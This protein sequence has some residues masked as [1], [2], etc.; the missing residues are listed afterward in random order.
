MAPVKTENVAPLSTYQ[1]TYLT[2]IDLSGLNPRTH[3]KAEDDAELVASIKAEGVLEP[4]LLRPHPNRTGRFQVVAGERRYHASIEAGLINVPAMVRDISDEK[5][6]ELA[7]TEN[8]QRRSM[9]PLDEANGFIKRLDMGQTSPEQ[10]ANTLG[11]SKRYVTDR[12]RLKK[13]CPT[14]MKGVESGEISVSHA[15]ILAKLTDEQQKDALQQNGDWVMDLETGKDKQ[16]LGSVAQLR[17]WV[18]ENVALDLSSPEV[19][20]E[21]PEVAE[22]VAAAAAKGATVVM[23]SGG[24]TPYQHKPKPGDP[25]FSDK[26]ERCKK[27]DKAAQTGVVID[28]RHR[29]ER[30][31]FK[32]VAPPKPATSSQ[33]SSMPGLSAAE[34]K[35]RDARVKR[36][37]ADERRRRERQQLWAANKAKAFE[38]FSAHIAKAPIKAVITALARNWGKPTADTADAFVRS[39]VINSTKNSLHSVDGFD[40]SAKGTG[41]DVKKWMKTAIAVAKKVAPAKP[42]KKAKK[43]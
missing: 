30:V 40:Y 12:I 13:L 35:R 19:Q 23:L 14:A 18:A 27:T 24:R 34:K 4:L 39:A 37:Q 5:L 38:A 20:A 42:T 22:E 9:H 41:F 3:F 26:W 17:D 16:V 25:L 2:L 32:P 15:I 43:R 8:I 7:L 10:L 11:L 29:G 1:F 28:G 21:F 31:H 33:T 6:L 36:E